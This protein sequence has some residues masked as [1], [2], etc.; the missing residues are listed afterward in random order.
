[1]DMSWISSMFGGG[2]GGG[3]G[4]GAA[5]STASGFYFGD[6]PKMQVREGVATGGGLSAGTSM[7]GGGVAGGVYP[8]AGST[9]LSMGADPHP[10]GT[11][12][13]SAP[14]QNS[15]SGQSG[16]GAGLADSLKAI[17]DMI[18]NYQVAGAYGDQI[19]VAQAPQTMITPQLATFSIPSVRR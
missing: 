6:T 1:M 18:K 15:M 17:G 7:P 4:G 3:G 19:A 11:L 5:P 12:A 8:A 9:P 16:V 2:A 14:T 10:A 13:G